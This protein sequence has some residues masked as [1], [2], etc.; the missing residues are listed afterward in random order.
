MEHGKSLTDA[1]RKAQV[2]NVHEAEQ[3]SCQGWRTNP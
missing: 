2:D 3:R 1:K